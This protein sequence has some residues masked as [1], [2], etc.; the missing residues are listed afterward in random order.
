MSFFTLGTQVF[1]KSMCVCG[2][3][4]DQMR[5]DLCIY[6]ALSFM[7][8]TMETVFVGVAINYH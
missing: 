2:N 4:K 7:Y 5:L 6:E 1:Q 8:I 3:L